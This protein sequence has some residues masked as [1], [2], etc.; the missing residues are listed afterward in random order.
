MIDLEDKR[1]G[2]KL[3]RLTS[4]VINYRV[5]MRSFATGDWGN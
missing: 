1:L 5:L 2:M 4:N 3:V